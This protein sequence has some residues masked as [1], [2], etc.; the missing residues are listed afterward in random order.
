MG[1]ERFVLHWTPMKDEHN[2]VVWVALTLG[3][4][5]RA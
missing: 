4:E 2:N 5:Q 3:N 1:F